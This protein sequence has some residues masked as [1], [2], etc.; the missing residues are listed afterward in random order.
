M[1]KTAAF[2]DHPHAIGEGSG[3]RSDAVKH[4]RTRPT[5]PLFPRSRVG[6]PL[7]DALR[8]FARVRRIA[9]ERRG[10]SKEA[11]PRG[12]VGTRENA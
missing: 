9:A 1:P 7:R 5:D 4:F 8:G 6:T 12:S 3:V 2:F 11:F 10:A